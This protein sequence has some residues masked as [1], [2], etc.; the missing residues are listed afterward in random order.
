MIVAFLFCFNQDPFGPFGPLQ[1]RE[2][3]SYPSQGQHGRANRRR[4]SILKGRDDDR[5]EKKRIE[6]YERSFTENILAFSMSLKLG[7]SGIIKVKISTIGN[8]T[9]VAYTSHI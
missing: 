6:Y 4:K 7:S 8:S 2:G 3:Q 5:C 9:I 1:D